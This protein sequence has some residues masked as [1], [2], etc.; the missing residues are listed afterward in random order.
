MR[1]AIRPHTPHATVFTTIDVEIFDKGRRL[2][3]IGIDSIGVNE[4]VRG[5]DNLVGKALLPV[6]IDELSGVVARKEHAAGRSGG[7]HAIGDHAAL[8]RTAKAS[9]ALTCN[10]RGAINDRALYLI[11][12]RTKRL[13]VHGLFELTGKRDILDDAGGAN[14]LKQRL[15]DSLVVKG[16]SVT[17]SVKRAIELA[18]GSEEPFVINHNVAI[19]HI[20]VARIL[21]VH[22][23]EVI[24]RRDVLD[25][26]RLGDGSRRLLFL[27]RIR[28]ILE[29]LNR[30]IYIGLR[31]IVVIVDDFGFRKSSGKGGP[32]IRC[33][34]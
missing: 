1:K 26:L 7:G 3:V 22:I 9:N 30:R 2:H 14:A 33:V 12:K 28:G 21:D 25:A 20:V 29:R 34:V 13:A 18:C 15:N 24:L 23:H 4:R 11:A 6:R 32:G 5:K 16:N 31:C 17:L 10:G 8:E 27:K 19:E